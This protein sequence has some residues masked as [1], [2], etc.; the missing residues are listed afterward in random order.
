[1]SVHTD[2][3]IRE[4]VDGVAAAPAERLS[5]VLTDPDTG[6][7]L[8]PQAASS[9]DALEKAIATAHQVHV[10][11]VWSDLPAAERAAGI[12][13]LQAELAS[14]AEELGRTDSIDSGVTV[15]M[16]SAVIGARVGMLELAAKQVED[17]FERVEHSTSFG[18]CDQWRL[19]WGPAAIFLPWNAGAAT[20]IMKTADALVAGCPVIIK[21]SEW[22][23]H[24][25][26][27][28]AEAVSAALPAGVVQIVHGDQTVGEALVNDAR[29]AAVS[30]TGGVGGGT[31]VAEACA[32]QLKPV[33]LELSGN[34]PVVVLPDATPDVVL[35]TVLAGMFFLNGQ[36]CIAPRRLVVPEEQAE[37]YV[38]AIGAALDGIKIGTTDDPETVLGPLA[39]AQHQQHIEAQLAD[40]ETRGCEVRRFGQLPSAG[41]HFVA[42]AVVLTDKAPDFRDE[43]FGPVLQVRTYASVDEAVD[44]AND[45]P[46]GLSAYVCG[47][48][49]D[50]A[51]AV[52]RRLRAAF[53]NINGLGQAEAPMMGNAWGK[54]GLGVF[55]IGQGA[56]FFA[57][58]RFVG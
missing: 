48:D 46:F 54:T 12:R 15:A 11:G 1:V 32:R 24:F 4:L 8:H 43:V 47:T 25:S 49:R 52:G 36:A 21:P 34:N 55:G 18:A 50:A 30:Y 37:G 3:G 26:G 42:P 58:Y 40:L 9:L 57:G 38:A 16:T 22:S 45:H 39:H 14:R 23:S 35:G 53:V 44:I 10:D 17:G 27:A 13:R 51:R 28:F 29:I 33:D 31:A 5:A 19:P 20:A 56:A 2:C 7:E 41:G 6:A